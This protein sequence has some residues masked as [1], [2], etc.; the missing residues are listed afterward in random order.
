MTLYESPL[1][2]KLYMIGRSFDRQLEII[3][4]E[5]IGLNEKNAMNYW[6]HGKKIL[7]R[8]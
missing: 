8:D 4:E 3:T 5:D 7:I 6:K 2:Y 1:P